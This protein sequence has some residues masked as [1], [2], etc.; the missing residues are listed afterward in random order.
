MSRING[1]IGGTRLPN[2]SPASLSG[3]HQLSQHK[4]WVSRGLLLDVSAIFATALWHLDASDA[5]KVLDASGN[6]AS[7]D[8]AVATWRDKTLGGRHVTMVNQPVYKH[9]AVNGKNAILFDG[10]DDYGT[11]TSVGT[12]NEFTLYAVVQRTSLGGGYDGAVCF[13]NR[14][15]VYTRLSSGQWGV[16]NVSGSQDQPSGITLSANQVA[17]IAVQRYSNHNRTVYTRQP[18]TG[19]VSTVVG[20]DS[21]SS[22]PAMVG[23]DG[24]GGQAHVG[25]IC[26]VVGFSE[27]HAETSRAAVIEYLASK[28]GVT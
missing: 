1:L 18:A 20:L 3:V 2:A 23:I 24:T 27:L 13:G 9:A 8:E 26:E 14:L 15:C 25:Y 4:E 10:A 7:A 12:L 17:V 19:I 5:T 16:Y 21:Y 22:Y 28:W 6:A 11:Y